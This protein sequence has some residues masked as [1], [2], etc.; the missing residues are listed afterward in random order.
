MQEKRFTGQ[1]AIITGAGI[2]IGFEIA[3]SLAKEGASIVLNDL[4]EGLAK[5]AAEKI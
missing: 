2:G 3:R 1:A 4:D 5:N